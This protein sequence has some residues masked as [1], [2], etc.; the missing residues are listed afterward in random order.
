MIQA[1]P[2]SLAWMAR[3]PV[4][5]RAFALAS[6]M[7]LSGS[8]TGC[9]NTD[10]WVDPIAARGWS[11]QYADAENSMPN[12]WRRASGAERPSDSQPKL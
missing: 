1:R 6:A 10:S 2:V 7:L 3:T 9:G 5:R 4:L 11:A 12:S 8:L